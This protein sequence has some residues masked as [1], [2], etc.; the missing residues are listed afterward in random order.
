[1]RGGGVL[2]LVAGEAIL[3][4]GPGETFDQVATAQ[5]GTITRYWV[6]VLIVNGGAASTKTT[7][8]S[9]RAEYRPIRPSRHG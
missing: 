4:R 7:S 5:G 6:W 1:M 9:W 8:W 3:Y 2:L